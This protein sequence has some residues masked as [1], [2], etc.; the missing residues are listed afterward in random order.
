MQRLDM[1]IT[2]YADDTILYCSAA[3]WEQALCKI[4]GGCR[5]LEGW[6]NMNGLR[7]NTTETKHICSSIQGRKM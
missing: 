3:A 1:N 6:C 7:V 2:L 5:E 4:Q